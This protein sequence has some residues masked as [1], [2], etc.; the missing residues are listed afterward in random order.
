MGWVVAAV[1][2]AVVVELTQLL[3]MPLV[4]LQLGILLLQDYRC[5]GLYG[6][7]MHSFCSVSVVLPLLQSHSRSSDCLATICATLPAWCTACKTANVTVRVVQV[8][9]SWRLR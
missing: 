9:M 2:A 6:I 3:S 1:E 7:H 4:G 5:A 8:I